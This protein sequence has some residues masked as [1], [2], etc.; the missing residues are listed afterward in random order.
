MTTA[1]TLY[2]FRD[3]YPN[4]IERER[5]QISTGEVYRDGAI[6]TI[7]SGTYKLLD[8][9]GDA[10]ITPQPTVT[11]PASGFA[12]VTL[13]AASLPSTLAYSDLYQEEWTLLIAGV[14]RVYRRE[15]IVCRRMI[16][17][18]ITDAD[19]EGGEYPNLSVWQGTVLT[20]W[21]SQIDEAWKQIIHRLLEEG[22]FPHRIFSPTSFRSAHRQRCYYLIFK[23][24]ANEYPGETR[25]EK[26]YLHHLDEYGQA[27]SKITFVEDRDQDGNPDSTKRKGTGGIIQPNAAPRRLS[28]STPRW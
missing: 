21:Q 2:T 28:S 26:A 13:S 5:E 12:T 7:T 17:P 10:I 24:L 22:H 8:A 19:L 14:T 15:A 25:W 27:W 3:P 4:I 6:A 18:V 9:S 16:Y 23:W 1:E 20:S 11:V